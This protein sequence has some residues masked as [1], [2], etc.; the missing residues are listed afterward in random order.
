MLRFSALSTIGL[1]LLSGRFATSKSTTGTGLLSD[2][3]S[4]PVLSDAFSSSMLLDFSVDDT[5]LTLGIRKDED[6]GRTIVVAEDEDG[7]VK[8][9][10]AE[11]NAC[12]KS[13]LEILLQISLAFLV[14]GNVFYFTKIHCGRE[15]FFP[16]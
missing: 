15:L 8:V 3:F 5:F 4:F 2:N 12:F 11:D 6:E 7:G 16:V 9:V 14:Y 1:F 13:S 10:A